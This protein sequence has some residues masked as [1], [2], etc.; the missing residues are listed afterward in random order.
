VAFGAEWVGMP[1]AG[2]APSF[3]VGVRHELGPVGLVLHLDYAFAQ[4]TDRTGAA[5]L[6]YSYSRVGGGATALYPLF[7]SGGFLA[8]GGGTL[9]YGYVTQAWKDGRHFEAGDVAAGAALRLSVPLWKARLALDLD[10]GVRRI[11][12]D[13]K[14]EV[15][16]AGGASFLLLYGF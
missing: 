12:V 9:G 15:Q 8:E 3:R 11:K 13:G 6:S 5:P 7:W 10:G 14:A 2:L 16:P 1:G 4:V